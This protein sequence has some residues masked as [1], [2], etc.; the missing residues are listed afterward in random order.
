MAQVFSCELCEIFKSAFFTEHLRGTASEGCH[1]NI[2]KQLL[3]GLPEACNVIEKETPTQ[4]FSR[5]FC[6]F[7][8]KTFFAEH[9]RSVTATEYFG[10][11]LSDSDP[12]K[13]FYMPCKNDLFHLL[14]MLVT[15][16]RNT[17]EI[18]YETK[19]TIV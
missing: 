15:A 18:I 8:R 9:L 5:G 4:V 1:F 6:E 14:Y 3:G 11:S 19:K 17:V 12:G 16:I 2:Q 13:L 10:I 7:L